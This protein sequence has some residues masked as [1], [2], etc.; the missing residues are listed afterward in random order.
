MESS[1]EKLFLQTNKQTK[2]H[3]ELCNTVEAE[4]PTHHPHLINVMGYINIVSGISNR[5]AYLCIPLSNLDL[6]M[7]DRSSL[8]CCYVQFYFWNLLK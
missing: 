6:L 8:G 7:K 3:E 1:L 2:T 4:L 5:F